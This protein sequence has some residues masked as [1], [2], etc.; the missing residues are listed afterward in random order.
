MTKPLYQLTI[1]EAAAGLAAGKFTSLELTNACLEHIAKQDS[2]VNAFVHVDTELAQR[3][4][5]QS[6]ARRAASKTLGILDG[7]P[8]NL[9]DIYATKE[10][11]TTASSHGFLVTPKYEVMVD[12]PMVNS[13]VLV[14]PNKTAPASQSFW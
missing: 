10:S 1:E 8:Y 3:Q 14:L 12:T 9:K 4:A 6:D 11:A 2:Q 5:E 7:I 13:S